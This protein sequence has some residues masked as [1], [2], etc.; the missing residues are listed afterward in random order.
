MKLELK[1]EKGLI[2]TIELPVAELVKEVQGL[3]SESA[4][5][6]AQLKER[7]SKKSLVDQVSEWVDTRVIAELVVDHLKSEGIPRTFEQAK[8]VWLDTL[9]MLGSHLAEGAKLAGGK[10]MDD[11]TPIEKAKFVLAWGKE[12]SLEDKAIFAEA[13]GLPIAKATAAE[14][15]EAEAKL[16]AGEK[17]EEPKIIEGKTDLPGY[18]FLEHLNMSIKEA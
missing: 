13:V 5:T 7:L 4:E 18:K 1:D 17:L 16:A 15:A 14:V 8:A 9:Q 3:G 6:E 11:F 10:T 2:G 12:L